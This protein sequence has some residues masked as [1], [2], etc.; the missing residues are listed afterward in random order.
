[1]KF[2]APLKLNHIFRRLYASEGHA[3][4]FLVLYARRNLKY[5]KIRVLW[6]SR[7]EGAGAS[8]DHP[9][10]WNAGVS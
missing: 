5:W 3:N 4:S 2:S 6:M 10:H 8:H 7:S 1:M 9:K